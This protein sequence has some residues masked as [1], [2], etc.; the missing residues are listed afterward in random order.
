MRSRSV[1]FFHEVVHSDPHPQRFCLWHQPQKSTLATA[2][3]VYVH[4]FAEE[5]NKARRMAALQS[6]ALADAGCSVLQM[7]LLGCGDSAGDFGDAS[8]DAW[9]ND[10]VAACAIAHQR[11]A[12]AWPDAPRP[13][14]W[15][16]GLR[17]GCLLASAAAARMTE[18]CNFLFWQPAASGKLVLQQFLRLKVA[19]SLGQADSRAVAEQLRTDLAAQRTVEVA[20]YR[21]APRLAVGLQQAQLDPPALQAQVIWVEITSR[22]EATLL[23]ASINSIAR[24]QQAGHAVG[25]HVVA[26]P[27]FWGTVEIED[28]PDLVIASTQ[29]LLAASA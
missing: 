5:M 16:W 13:T 28:A 19:A 18:P 15:L 10:V 9:V 12:Q 24:W 8:W 17:A 4:P 21:L 14:L 27:S 6:A 7:D 23:P 20:G 11:Y 29:L 26:G 3:V 1:A 2:L 25:E 22:E